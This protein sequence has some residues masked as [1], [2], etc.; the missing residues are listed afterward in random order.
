MAL[1][2]IGKDPGS[3]VNDSP[4]VWLDEDDGS[5]VLQGWKITDEA[6]LSEVTAKGPVPDHETLM[7]LPARMAPILREVC[8]SDGTGGL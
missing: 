4:T 7:R 2:F 6:T 1:L 5:I 8:G 3:P